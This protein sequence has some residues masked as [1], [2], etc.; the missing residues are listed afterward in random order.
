MG[1]AVKIYQ[2]FKE[3]E[4]KARILAEAFEELEKRYPQFFDLPTKEELSVVKLELQKEI[5]ELRKEIKQLEGEW[6]KEIV[7]SKGELEIKIE[8]I[9]KEI[10]QL[11][12]EL[13]ERIEQTRKEIEQVRGEFRKEIEQTRKE[14]E[15][16]KGELQKE[17]EQVKGSLKKEIEQVKGELKK[18]IEDFRKEEAR[19]WVSGIG[20]S[21]GE[22]PSVRE[23]IKNLREE[24]FIRKP[25]YKERIK[26]QQEVLNLPL[27]PTTT[28]GSFPQTEEVRRVRL[29][30][31]KGRLSEEDDKTF[32]RGNI[33]S[34]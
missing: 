33:I 6:R 10:E 26:K 8:Q 32:I 34:T 21:F 18:E 15:Q 9:R 4:E 28:I 1:Y 25:E 17:I 7:K 22:I 31:R 11:R 29:L 20:S 23:R 2:A 3:D 16:I 19:K 12:G 14:I 13:S 5:E 27:F 30:Y 24:D